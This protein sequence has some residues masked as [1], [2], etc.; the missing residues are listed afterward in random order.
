MENNICSMPGSRIKSEKMENQLLLYKVESRE[1]PKKEPKMSR[2]FCPICGVANTFEVDSCGWLIIRLCL[3]CAKKEKFTVD[4]SK[5][6]RC[7]KCGEL[8]IQ[9][10]S[11]ICPVCWIK[12]F[13]EE[14]RN[15]KNS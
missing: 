1:Q 4:I 10:K 9:K 5:A 11:P 14:K 15:G 12:Y 13:R 3:K 2:S 8:F 7:S 6:I